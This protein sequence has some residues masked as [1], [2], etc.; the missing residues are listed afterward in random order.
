MTLVAAVFERETGALA[1]G[2]TRVR[3]EKVGTK[4][5]LVQFA[6]VDHEPHPE[7]H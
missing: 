1:F 7:R 2:A 4:G 6:P 5:R 3:L